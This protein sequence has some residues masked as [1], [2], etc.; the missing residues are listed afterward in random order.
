MTRCVCGGTFDDD[1]DRYYPCDKCGSASP[2]EAV[3]F[4][5]HRQ[6]A[7]RKAMRIRT[8]AVWWPYNLVDEHRYPS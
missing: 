3:R 5:A 7:R 4:L 1:G 8:V 2:A 6:E